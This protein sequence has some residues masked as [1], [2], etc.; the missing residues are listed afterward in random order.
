M[1]A[2]PH[3]TVTLHQKQILISIARHPVRGMTNAEWLEAEC[4]KVLGKDEMAWCGS[5]WRDRIQQHPGKL[6]RVLADMNV[7]R[8]EGKRIYNP[9]GFAEDLWKRFV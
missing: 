5:R 4:V 8:R 9:G 2:P 7:C 3:V 1:N 6:E